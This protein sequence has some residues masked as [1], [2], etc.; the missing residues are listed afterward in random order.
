MT[1]KLYYKYNQN[2]RDVRIYFENTKL[3]TNKKGGKMVPMSLFACKQR[4]TKVS[5]PQK[6]IIKNFQI[7]FR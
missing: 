6:K 7:F 5:F 3:R 1:L 4:K 2:R